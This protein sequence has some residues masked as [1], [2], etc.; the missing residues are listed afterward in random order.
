MSKLSIKTIIAR[1]SLLFLLTFLAGW[2]DAT[3]QVSINEVCS[4]NQQVLILNDGSSP[5]WIELY[6]ED[7]A[8]VEL[9]GYYLTD[10]PKDTTKWEFG[11]ISVPA[12]GF[13]IVYASG[14]DDTSGN[15]PATSFKLSQNGETLCL[16]SPNKELV[17]SMVIPFI[18]TD[19]SYGKQTDG[20]STNL[21]FST[22]T[23]STSNNSSQ[24]SDH[25][26]AYPPEFSKI[27]GLFQNAF[28]FDITTNE[29]SG[30]ILYTVN[31]SEP[32]SNSFLYSEP[33]TVSSN[34]I[35]K[36]KTFKNGL[37]PSK[38]SV[39]NYIFLENQTLPVV[40]LTTHPGYFFD[41]DTGIY[42]LG[43]NASSEFPYHGANF[44]S[45]K[46]VPVNLQWYD[47][48]GRLGFD[49]DLGVQIHG[50]SISR[51][52]P[53]RSLRLLAD[54]KY[55]KEEIEYSLFST[56][57]LPKNKRFI[58]RN[59]GSDYLKTM[60]RDGFIHNVFISNGLHVDA[61]CFNPV[62]VYLNGDF[63][64][65][66][67]A[68]EKID[69]Y[70]VQYNYGYDDDEVDMLEEQDQVVEGN[71]DL[72]NQHEALLL[73]LDLSDD[74]NF[75]TAA[76][77]FDVKNI[78]DYYISQTYIN[79]L[80]WPYN[81]LKYWRARVDSSKWR[82]VIFDLDATLGGVSFAPV[83]FDALKR[84]LGSFGD[85]NRHVIVFRKL[86][87]NREYFEYFINRY[88]D[89]V[90]TIFSA[91]KFSTAVDDAASRIEDVI[92]R[93]YDRWGAEE[94]DWYDEVDIVRNYVQERPPYA[95]SY[96]QQ[97]FGLALKSNIHLNVYPPK[98]GN[99]EINT[100]SLREF[101]FNGVYF[102][103]VP[104]QIGINE[105][106]GFRFHHWESNRL[107]TDGSSAYSKTFQPLD[108][109]SLTAVFVGKSIFD[110]LQVFPNPSTGN[111]TVRFVVNERQS[112]SISITNID[113]REQLE[114]TNTVLQ[115]GSHELTFHL[116]E[117]LQGL[118]LVKVRTDN[119]LYTEKL[120]LVKP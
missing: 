81:N 95:L 62:E 38:T 36:A 77:L 119:S 117:S 63:W 66:H 30:V 89:L 87:E 53:M 24:G 43:P 57:I 75:E 82:Y 67:N 22:P 92:P 20:S 18:S 90:N 106:P 86:L 61:V 5:D 118:F 27:G 32:D 102:E 69:R 74:G 115:G 39:A 15:P 47:T 60:F 50:G 97:F 8:A 56:K 28:E 16:Y 31:G 6:N 114:L 68:R 76:S 111:L 49:Q 1:I 103:D 4:S 78:A 64:G 42:M 84:A 29:P 37:L 65:I 34:S 72:F 21:F 14:N 23:P 7:E 88:C 105:N 12:Q 70:Y 40:C 93:H 48:Y 10:N 55:G 44:W 116:E 58:L 83:E 46:R 2:L 113:G 73:N 94:N 110:P 101:P 120:I 80:D 91:K 109:D 3:A 35:I 26:I 99:L 45:D 41:T 13:L 85:T 104:I 98:A 25:I 51:T 100:I 107:D 79:N 52:R 17:D 9:D 33:L 71:F 112:V 108:G 96:L 11:S 54:D 59:S 19:L